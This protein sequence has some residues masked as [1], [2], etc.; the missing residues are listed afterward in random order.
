MHGFFYGEARRAFRLPSTPMLRGD[1]LMVIS[2]SLQPCHCLG[3]WLQGSND[4][5]NQIGDWAAVG[6][7]KECFP[8]VPLASCVPSLFPLLCSGM[9]HQLGGM[10]QDGSRS[11]HSGGNCPIGPKSCHFILKFHVTSCHLLYV[12]NGRIFPVRPSYA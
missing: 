12:T 4:N 6:Y 2:I 8:Q 3:L 10:V 11:E 7:S 1:E 5:E 9:T